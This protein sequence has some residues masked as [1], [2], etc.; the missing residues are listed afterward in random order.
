MCL[1][2][3]EHHVKPHIHVHVFH[4]YIPIKINLSKR[5]KQTN[6]FQKLE[7][8]PGASHLQVIPALYLRGEAGD[9]LQV[10]G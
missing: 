3:P 6:I 4:C 10:T 9:E 1:H 7:A 5:F 2:L 8:G